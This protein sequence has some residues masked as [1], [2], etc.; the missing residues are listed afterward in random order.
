MRG[1]LGFCKVDLDAAMEAKAGTTL[2]NAL[3]SN[4]GAI[5]TSS[6]ANERIL[7]GGPT[8]FANLNFTEVPALGI[9][10]EFGVL[11]NNGTKLCGDAQSSG[12]TIDSTIKMSY[13]TIELP[14]L[15]TYTVNKGNFLEFMPQA[16]FYA[17]FPVGKCNSDVDMTIAYKSVKKDFSNDGTDTIDNSCIFGLALGSEASLNFSKTSALLFNFRWLYDFN[18][19]KLSGDE[20]GRRTVFLLSAGYKHTIR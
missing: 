15:L 7:A 4:T 3:S 17:S 16:G 19:L 1:S 13:T 11:F 2:S 10:A 12:Y 9:Q 5:A 14:I 20:V 18:K 6:I 8:F